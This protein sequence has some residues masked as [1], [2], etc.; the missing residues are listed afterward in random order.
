MFKNICRLSVNQNFIIKFHYQ[1][2]FSDIFFTV[3]CT[4]SDFWMVRSDSESFRTSKNLWTS[5]PLA[6]LSATQR[7]G[8]EHR[9]KI[10]F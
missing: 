6:G 5:K 10:N 3:G 9:K 2:Q 8:S 1:K 7:L 4:S